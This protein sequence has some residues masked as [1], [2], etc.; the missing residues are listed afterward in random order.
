MREV[1]EATIGDHVYK[2][3]MLGSDQGSKVL[4]RLMRIGGKGLAQG[5]LDGEGVTKMFGALFDQLTDENL[6]FF[7]K[8]FRAVTRVTPVADPVEGVGPEGR[9]RKPLRR[10]VR[11]HG[12]L[13]ERV[14]GGELRQFF[15]R[16]R[17]RGD[18]RGSPE[19]GVDGEDGTDWAVWGLVAKGWGSLIEIQTQWSF[20]DLWLGNEALKEWQQAEKEATKPR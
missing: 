5:G 2:I 6:D 17:P 15:R 18:D 16:A 13:A 10:Q 3:E 9:L 4:A 11:R 1:K 7:T 19:C 12:P 20:E 14:R 8:T